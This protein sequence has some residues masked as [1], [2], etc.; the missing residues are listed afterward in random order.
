MREFNDEV[1]FTDDSIT[2]VNREGIEFL[3]VAALRNKR[4]RI[5]LCTHR[6]VDDTVH[7]MLIVHTSG[8]YVR[9]HKHPNKSE[10]FHIIEGE[11]DIVVFDDEGEMIEVVSLGEYGSGKNFFWRISDSYYHT[12]IP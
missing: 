7:E 5:R 4:E 6:S 9:P 12:H 11:L 1:L 10:S 2:K 3:K 8:G